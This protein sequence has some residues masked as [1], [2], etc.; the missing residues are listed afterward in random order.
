M[1]LLT[2]NLI[3]KCNGTKHIIRV[4]GG[5]VYTSYFTSCK[6]LHRIFCYNQFISKKKYLVKKKFSVYNSCAP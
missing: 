2:E 5:G 6:I 3:I 1:M 4:G